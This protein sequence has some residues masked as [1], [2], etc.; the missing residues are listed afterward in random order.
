MRVAFILQKF[1]H[2]HFWY[3][4]SIS[5][6]ISIAL[7]QIPWAN[8]TMHFYFSLAKFT[9][10]F[11]RYHFLVIILG[12]LVII[13]YHSRVL[14]RLKQFCSCNISFPIL[15]QIG[16]LPNLGIPRVNTTLLVS[17]FGMTFLRYRSKVL[18]FSVKTFFLL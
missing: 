8:F 4:Y 11:P 12:F 7:F 10:L 3:H 1:W 18:P 13:R 14:F 2:M 17:H 16:S 9:V 6:T 5:F 15:H